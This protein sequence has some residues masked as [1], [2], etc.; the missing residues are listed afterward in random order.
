MAT[1]MIDPSHTS[2]TRELTG[3]RVLVV[4][5]SPSVLAFAEAALRKAGC[6]VRTSDDIW[7]ASAISDFRPDLVLIDVHLAGG[8]TGPTVIRA[9][10]KRALCR[11]VRYVLYSTASAEELEPLA[12]SCDADGC[13]HKDGDPAALVREVA[14][15]LE[16]VR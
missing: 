16:A 7:I 14:R 4:D 6:E 5:D 15:V 8:C 11:D 3:A 12:R 9:L 1:P 2:R 13:L 10:K